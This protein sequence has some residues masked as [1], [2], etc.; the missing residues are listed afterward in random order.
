MRLVEQAAGHRYHTELLGEQE[1]AM[2]T[3]GFPFDETQR[4]SA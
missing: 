2:P 3:E 1:P 4:N